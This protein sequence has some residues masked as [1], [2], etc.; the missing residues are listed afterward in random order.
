MV[1]VWNRDAI[2][3]L[4]GR[5]HSAVRVRH[6]SKTW[7]EI[8]LHLFI[9]SAVSGGEV[10]AS[11]LNSLTLRGKSPWHPRFSGPQSR[12]WTL[13]RRNKYLSPHKN[14]TTRITK[15]FNIIKVNQFANVYLWYIY[16]YIYMYNKCSKWRNLQKT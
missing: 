13:C 3:F 5:K 1:C 8:H 2:N 12:S 11:R 16:I 15:L 4:W 7:V 14:R 9:N 10:S 6:K